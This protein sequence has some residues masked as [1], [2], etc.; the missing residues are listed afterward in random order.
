MYR[1]LIADDEP[2]QTRIL[3]EIIKRLRPQY[4]ITA[5]G[6]G[7]EALEFIQS[8]PVDI[9]ITDIKMPVMD[10]LEMLENLREKLHA[11]RVVLLTGY[12]DFE[13]AKRGIRLG[14]FDYMLKPF[15]EDQ[16]SELLQ[17]LEVSLQR[18]R[19]TLYSQEKLVGEMN[20]IFP[21]YVQQLFFKWVNGTLSQAEFSEFSQYIPKLKEAFVVVCEVEGAGPGGVG[22]PTEIREEIKENIRW[23]VDEVSGAFGIPNSFFVDGDSDLLISVIGLNPDMHQIP[24]LLLAQYRQVSAQVKEK[25][26]AAISIGI[27]RVTDDIR[28]GLSRSYHEALDALSLKFFLGA[29][30]VLDYKETQFSHHLKQTWLKEKEE[31]ITACFKRR[32]EEALAKTLEEVF[33]SFST[34]GYVRPSMAVD[35]VTRLVLG[36]ARIVEE[37]ME[38]AGYR[39]M[40]ALIQ[41]DLKQCRSMDRLADAAKM[42]IREVS[43]VYGNLKSSKD[44][45]IMSQCLAYLEEHYM[46]D[47]SLESVAEAF[48]FNP[49]YFSSYFKTKTGTNFSEYLTA[50][51][52]KKARQMLADS[53]RKIEDVA[54]GVGY[55]NVRYFNRLFKK[56]FNVTPQEY[57]HRLH[58]K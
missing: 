26:N 35:T 14:I 4:E 17:K 2:L 58:K 34:G 51:R 6:N 13:Y 23:L 12:S 49:S 20:K 1:V 37:N 31:A 45:Q 27:G 30:C 11:M 33:G 52:L 39:Q 28:G 22:E 50:I 21:L 43:A 47:I 44:Q 5:S 3:G 40:T 54:A 56:E 8:N 57:R 7:K 38:E 53:G 18:E 48:F 42:H 36:V 25:W 55:R 41:K 24:E 16:V 32:E 19:N 15:D 10:G 9:V 29:G 46:E